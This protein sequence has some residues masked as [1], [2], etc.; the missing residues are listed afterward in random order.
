[1]MSSTLDYS[2]V[3]MAG[4]LGS[5]H[6][7][8]MC[9]ALVSGFFMNRSHHDYLPYLA[10]HMA[11]LGVY[12]LI[13]IVAASFGF[14]VV[15]SGMVGKLQ[16]FLQFIIGAIVIMLA[17]GILGLSPWQGSV[18][19]LPMDL[20]QK[21]FRKAAAS[22]RIKGAMIGGMLNGFVPC[23]LTFAMAVSVTSAAT[24][25]QGGLTMLIFGVGTLPTMLFVSVA[26]GKIGT[27]YRNYMLKG[28]AVIMII[29]GANTMFK[30]LAFLGTREGGQHP[31]ESMNHAMPM[32]QTMPMDHKMPADHAM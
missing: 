21:G 2:M 20:L 11:R 22:G 5:G 9:G 6:C 4:V 29:M 16:G 3:F 19:L 26:F 13:G 28:A 1:M 32:D 25:F 7:V 12:T 23:P 15:S 17:A 30:G 14:A 27:R 24:P 10:Y 31:F 8:G 18:R